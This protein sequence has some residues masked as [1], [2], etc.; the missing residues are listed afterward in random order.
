M[1]TRKQ[2]ISVEHVGALN[3]VE[4]EF[5]GCKDIEK[6]WKNYLSH[7]NTDPEINQ[8]KW[9]RDRDN[10]LAL[11][12]SEMSKIL[13]YKYDTLEIYQ[14]GYSP[15]GWAH[16]DAVSFGALEYIRQLSAGQKTVP[17]SIL[18]QPKDN[19]NTTKDQSE[20]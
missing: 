20:H 15:G 12:L 18:D 14:G 4:V 8:A 13:G 19:S 11:M 1:S 10:L 5:Y 2:L 6:S 17:I 9:I 3:L 16:R 7:L